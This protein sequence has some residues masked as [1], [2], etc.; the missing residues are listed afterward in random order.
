MRTLP[1]VTL[2]EVGRFT[3][4]SF[5]EPNPWL[6]CKAVA[7][8][9]QHIGRVNFGV[10]PLGDRVY[11]DNLAVDADFQRKGYA[12]S[13]LLAVVRDSS[14]PSGTLPVTA[15]HE[16]WASNGFWSKLR[17]GGVSGLTVT[18]DVRASE[19]CKEAERWKALSPLA[20]GSDRRR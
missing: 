14:P 3:S 7:A 17:A 5:V 20:L 19:M 2:I 8:D 9:G 16:V 13:I 15:L 6:C 12:T 4:G 11:V 18:Q 10:S 1:A